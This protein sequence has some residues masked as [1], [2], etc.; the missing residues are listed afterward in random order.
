MESF[1]TI[2]NRGT[3]LSS[4]AP[5]GAPA[6]RGTGMRGV[7]ACA[8]SAGI[9]ARLR[10]IALARTAEVRVAA[11]AYVA[12]RTADL[13]TTKKQPKIYVPPP[14]RERSP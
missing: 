7:V 14:R 11:A 2:G 5:M 9:P 13:P 4:A 1:M 3:T 8:P 6:G 12:A 10:H